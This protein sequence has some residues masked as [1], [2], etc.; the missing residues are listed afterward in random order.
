MDQFLSEISSVAYL[1][2]MAMDAIETLDPAGAILKGL[3]G[4]G[5]STRTRSSGWEDA[6]SRMHKIATADKKSII[7]P[8][9]MT[10]QQVWSTGKDEW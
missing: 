9:G 1:E 8:P 3:A 7:V 6:Y 5:E 10:P 4:H 2:W